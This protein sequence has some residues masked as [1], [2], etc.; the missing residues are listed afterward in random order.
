MPAIFYKVT[1]T[2]NERDE[3][4]ALIKSGKRAASAVRN[5]LVLLG[6]DAGEH[7]AHRQT[8]QQLCDA[9]LVDMRTIDRV[10]RRFVEEGMDAALHRK[11][12]GERINARR[13]DGQAEARLIALYCSQPP[14]GRSRWTL[15]LLADKLV[16][17]EVCESLSH[18]T[19]RQALKKTKSNP[20]R[21]NNG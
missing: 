17:L 3:L 15:R 11:S 19:V 16:E 9:L 6:T 21:K 4:E 10:K 13:I 2:R 18:E 7:Q 20:G 8:N 12:G 1:L 14:K 5:A